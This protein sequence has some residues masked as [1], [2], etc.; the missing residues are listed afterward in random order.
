MFWLE[1]S[2]FF[3]SGFVGFFWADFGV[4]SDLLQGYFEE[5]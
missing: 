4:V 5:V 1:F 3:G 2:W